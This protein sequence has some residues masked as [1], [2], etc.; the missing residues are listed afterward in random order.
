MANGWRA[1][2]LD[3]RGLLSMEEGMRKAGSSP[4]YEVGTDGTNGT[5]TVA[6]KGN[7]QGEMRRQLELEQRIEDEFWELVGP[8]PPVDD[9]KV[10]SHT[11]LAAKLHVMTAIS[12]SLSMII[13]DFNNV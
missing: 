4:L 11:L 1:K 10:G 5:A 13:N 8:S 2:Y 3:R 6:K 9:V 7:F 12:T